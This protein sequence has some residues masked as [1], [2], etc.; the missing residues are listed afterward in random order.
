MWPYTHEEAA[1]L[2]HPQ[3]AEEVDAEV[4]V[5]LRPAN[6]EMPAVTVELAAG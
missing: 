4:I 5:L 6:D 1:W 3:A 2:A